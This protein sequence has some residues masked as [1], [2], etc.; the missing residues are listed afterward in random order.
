MRKHRLTG[1]SSF[2]P[3]S[4]LSLSHSTPCGVIHRD[5]SR[6]SQKP[7]RLGHY[8]FMSR[9]FLIV[10]RRPSYGNGMEGRRRFILYVV[11]NRQYGHP[12]YGQGLLVLVYG[13]SHFRQKG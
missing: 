10:L 2:H 4:Y 7:F 9:P 6:H 13:R 12:T 3:L 1:C 8:T 11:F 5:S